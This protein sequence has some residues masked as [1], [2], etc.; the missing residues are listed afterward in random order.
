[1]KKNSLRQML[2]ALTLAA[3]ATAGAQSV[4]RMPE[5]GGATGDPTRKATAAA[6]TA[7][8]AQADPMTAEADRVALQQYMDANGGRR[9]VAK[10]PMRTPWAADDDTFYRFRGQNNFAGR[11]DENDQTGFCGL[12]GFNLFNEQGQWAWK[13]DTLVS[14]DDIS[15]YSVP[16]ESYFYS[17]RPQQGTG[18]ITGAEITKFSKQTMQQVGEKWTI[19]CD[20]QSGIPYRGLCYDAKNRQVFTT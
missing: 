14:N 12:V 9:P 13:C 19:K 7:D 1:M 16:T 4:F 5:L 10:A 6:T 15:P 20:G 18:G 3:T 2:V 8:A 17:Y 11:A